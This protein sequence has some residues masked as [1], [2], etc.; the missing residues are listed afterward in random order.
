MFLIHLHAV[1]CTSA[2]ILYIYIYIYIYVCIVAANIVETKVH[3]IL[4]KDL[5]VELKK[6]MKVEKTSVCQSHE[7]AAL[8]VN[9][10]AD[11]ISDDL[12]YL[13]I[14][15]VTG[16]DGENGD[17][18]LNRCDGLQVMITFIATVDLPT[19]GM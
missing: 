14:D 3:R 10:V 6:P 5:T 18:I 13:Y 9:N 16:L 1:L 2:Y 7:Q 4:G 12:L 19:G 11:T 15:N 17:Y 8:L